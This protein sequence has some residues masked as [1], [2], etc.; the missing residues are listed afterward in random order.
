M[1][2]DFAE[3]FGQRSTIGWEQFVP[4]RGCP[5]RIDD[6]Q[7]PAITALAFGL[8]DVHVDRGATVSDT[9]GERG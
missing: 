7:Y 3:R 5:E 1:C 2:V 9:R 6:F 8:I 4:H